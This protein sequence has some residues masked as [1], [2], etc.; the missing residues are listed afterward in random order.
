MNE[1]K[2]HRITHNRILIDVRTDAEHDYYAFALYS[3]Y[4]YM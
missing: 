4:T 2:H 1:C 3:L